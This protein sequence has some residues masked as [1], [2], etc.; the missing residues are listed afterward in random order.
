MALALS[1]SFEVIDPRFSNFA[2]G[3]VHVEKLFTG[4][5]WAEGPAWFPAGRYL[6]WSDIPNDRILRWDETDSSVSVFRQPAMNSNGHS[7]DREGRLVSCEHRGRCVSRTE[8]DGRRPRD[9]GHQ[10]AHDDRDDT[11]RESHRKDDEAGDWCP[12]VAQIARGGVEGC[13]EQDR[14]DE[15]RECQLRRNAERR[16]AGHEGQQRT[17][18]G[19]EDRVRCADAPRSGG[20]EDAG[21]EEAEKLFELAHPPITSHRRAPCSGRR[22]ETASPRSSILIF[23]ALYKLRSSVV[24]SRESRL[25]WPDRVPRLSLGTALSLPKGAAMA[26][27]AARRQ[28]RELAGAL[29]FSRGQAIRLRASTLR[30]DKFTSA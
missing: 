2:F 26:R 20:E 3:N 5:R 10:G 19:E 7:V 23:E 16:R 30:R 21:E 25:R 13:V 24:L 1:S 28:L 14:R 4:C 9:V 17:A 27:A 6:V 15:Q 22:S 18:E 12:V 8:H 11:R 29:A